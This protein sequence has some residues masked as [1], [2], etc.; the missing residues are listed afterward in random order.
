MLFKS[1]LSVLLV[2]GA[3]QKILTIN[4]F[5]I[6]H[7]AAGK[8][9]LCDGGTKTSIVS[10]WVEKGTQISFQA[11]DKDIPGQAKYLI[12]DESNNP[13]YVLLTRGNTNCYMPDP[14]YK[15][16]IQVGIM[17]IRF[18]S[19]FCKVT[20]FFT[21]AHLVACSGSPTP[22]QQVMPKR[23]ETSDFDN[24]S[25]RQNPSWKVDLQPLREEKYNE[26]TSFKLASEIFVA[27]FDDNFTEILLLQLLSTASK[28][29]DGVLSVNRL[30]DLRKARYDLSRE[31]IDGKNFI[32][33]NTWGSLRGY[34]LVPDPAEKFRSYIKQYGWSKPSLSKSLVF[35]FYLSEPYLMTEDD[36]YVLKFD[37]YRLNNPTP[38][39]TLTTYHYRLKLQR[40]NSLSK[41]EFTLTRLING[42]PNGAENKLTIPYS[43]ENQDWIH[44]T[45]SFGSGILYHID[46]DNVRVKRL[47]QVRAWFGGV[48]YK[49][50]P[51][52][53]YETIF[54]NSIYY[55]KD[56][57]ATRTVE[58]SLEAYRDKTMT[59]SKKTN[60]FGLRLWKFVPN[61]GLFPLD[62]VG[63]D[64]NKDPNHII[65]DNRCIIDEI[66]R[67][68][69]NRCTAYVFL[70]NKLETNNYAL[71][72]NVYGTRSMNCPAPCRYCIHSV[73]C[74][75]AKDGFNEDLNFN[76]NFRY[77]RE[78]F[79]D[80]R[81]DPN[82]PKIAKRFVKFTN[83]LGRDYYVRCP[84]NCKKT[85]H[86]SYI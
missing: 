50:T 37:T 48:R 67:V 26:G 39:Q 45:F 56:G 62:E 13:Q 53:Y 54:R 19:N 68:G 2:E 6:M 17:M 29:Y 22:I 30:N 41:F 34:H 38:G 73:V 84:I 66:D 12:N 43:G 5:N 49:S 72:T 25:Y 81:Y 23:G 64:H 36:I 24:L 40:L 32:K 85:I 31:L 4:M 58:V 60:D 77:M 1:L 7:S 65:P 86:V 59:Q 51:S 57:S 16:W 42:A 33:R 76:E 46:E 82:K 10:I 78:N 83:N 18:Q 28:S 63:I 8:N 75:F 52:T 15:G 80:T 9:P 69:Q 74:T 61:V 11:L 27:D 44:F 70:K 3:L 71:N 47:E 21:T 35:Q 20:H 79:P 55:K 14:N